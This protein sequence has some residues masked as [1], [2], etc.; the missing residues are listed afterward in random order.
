MTDLNVSNSNFSMA[1]V[2]SL[3]SVLKDHSKC[4][5]TILYL[6]DCHISSEGAVKLATALYKNTTL[7]A[8]HLNIN[9]SQN[10]SRQQNTDMVVLAILSHQQGRRGGTGDCTLQELN[11]E[12]PEV[13][14]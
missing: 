13:E 11:S 10:V 12:T 7:N 8:L 6:Q 9:S 14:P 2:N 4:T 5:L 1:N 3:A